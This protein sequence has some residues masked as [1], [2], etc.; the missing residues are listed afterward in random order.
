[1]RMVFVQGRDGQISQGPDCPP[2]GS[3]GGAGNASKKFPSPALCAREKRVFYFQICKQK[4]CGAFLRPLFSG[5]SSHYVWV[6]VATLAKLLRR[7]ARCPPILWGGVG[8]NPPPPQG[9]SVM[10]TRPKMTTR[11]KMT[12]VNELVGG[13]RQFGR[14]SLSGA[15]IWRPRP[16]VTPGMVPGRT[17]LSHSWTPAQGICVFLALWASPKRIPGTKFDLFLSHLS[18]IEVC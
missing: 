15:V 6:N 9:L 17:H 12:Q 3:L 5:V 10:T 7:A 13:G 4:K 14:L 11:S 2:S 18:K 16:S 8:V 1:M